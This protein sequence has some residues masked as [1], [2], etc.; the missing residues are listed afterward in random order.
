M[1]LNE[2]IVMC[3]KLSKMVFE[4]INNSSYIFFRI[5]SYTFLNCEGENV[6]FLDGQDRCP[7]NTFAAACSIAVWMKKAIT[8]FFACLALFS[9]TYVH[10]HKCQHVC[11]EEGNRKQRNIE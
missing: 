11:E 9:T 7:K 5:T 2:L 1:P 3:Q 10:C 4:F 6:L 8:S